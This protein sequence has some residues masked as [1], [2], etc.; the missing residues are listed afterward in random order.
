VVSAV[1][2]AVVPFGVVLESQVIQTL[3][4][5]VE[6]VQDGLV[7]QV[8]LVVLVSSFSNGNLT[9][10]P[11]KFLSLQTQVNSEYLMV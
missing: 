10:L 11:I 4:V 9:I 1:A 6:V 3:A 5:V 7:S 2:V 8:G